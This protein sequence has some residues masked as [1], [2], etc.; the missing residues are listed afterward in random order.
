MYLHS[1]RSYKK[2]NNC[3]EVQ[4]NALSITTRS[5]IVENQKMWLKIIQDVGSN[6]TRTVFNLD[7]CTHDGPIIMTLK[8]IHFLYLLTYAVVVKCGRMVCC[9]L[10]DVQFWQKEKNMCCF[11]PEILLLPQNSASKADVPK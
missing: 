7:L 9:L 10:A 6:G 8:L 1:W 4:Y 11:N 3:L 2:L 5:C